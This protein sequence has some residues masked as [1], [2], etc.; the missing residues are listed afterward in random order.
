MRLL[1]FFVLVFPLAL[2]A[3]QPWTKSPGAW[4]LAEVNEILTDSPWSPARDR[5]EIALLTRRIDPLTNL[6]TA[7]PSAPREGGFVAS[8]KTQGAPLPTGSVLWWSSKTVR[9]AQQRRRQLQGNIPANAPLRVGELHN[10][11]LAVE[12][13]EP[14]RILRDAVENIRETC[15]LEIPGGGTLDATD[16]RF[17]ES[18]HAG[19]DFTAFQFPRQLKGQ[20]AFSPDLLQITFRCKATAKIGRSGGPNTLSVRATFEPRKMR[21]NGKPDL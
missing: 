7:M 11:V 6:P 3:G 18:G 2:A 20:A 17:V 16:V 8:A 4:T 13:A 1:I 14:M 10:F 15:Y 12:G 9:L 5:I 21:V 19:E